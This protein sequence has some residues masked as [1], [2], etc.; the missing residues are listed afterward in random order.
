MPQINM[1]KTDNSI[2]VNGQIFQGILLA[3]SVPALTEKDRVETWKRCLEIQTFTER[4]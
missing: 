3:G 4:K 2:E 1:K